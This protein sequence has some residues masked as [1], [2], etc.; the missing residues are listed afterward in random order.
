MPQSWS[1]QPCHSTAWPDG[2]PLCVCVCVCVGGRGGGKGEG[3]EGRLRRRK[4]KELRGEKQRKDMLY[5]ET[6]TSCVSVIWSS[7]YN[8]AIN[9]FHIAAIGAMILTAVLCLLWLFVY[10]IHNWG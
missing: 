2:N 8:W 7:S 4:N 9:H 10:G 5:Y 1:V 6:L 3:S